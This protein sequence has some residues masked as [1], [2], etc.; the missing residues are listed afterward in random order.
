MFDIEFANL[1]V[2]GDMG[3]ADKG[4]EGV[5]SLVTPHKG[6]LNMNVSVYLW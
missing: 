2:E 3:L 1:L 4:Y 5:P 6:I